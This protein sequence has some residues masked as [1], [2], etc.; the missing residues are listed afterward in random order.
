VS[1]GKVMTVTHFDRNLASHILVKIV[2]VPTAGDVACY[3]DCENLRQ[4][5]FSSETA[6]GRNR[7]EEFVINPHSGNF[8]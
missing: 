4:A 8:P 3:A 1:S 2:N 7:C 5:T 6:R